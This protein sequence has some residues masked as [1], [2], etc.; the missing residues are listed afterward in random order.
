[1][2][3]LVF[4]FP[5]F[6]H[7]SKNVRTVE[8]ECNWFHHICVQRFMGPHSLIIIVDYI[9]FGGAIIRT[10]CTLILYNYSMTI[11]NT[12]AGVMR[13][14]LTDASMFFSLWR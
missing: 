10:K 13:Y 1:M 3:Y 2:Y 12:F 11:D 8:S 5:N 7:K 14:V 4:V 9:N 6:K